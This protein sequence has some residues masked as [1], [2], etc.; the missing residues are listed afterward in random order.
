MD[1]PYDVLMQ[2]LELPCGVTVKNRFFKAP[3]S[4][5]MGAKDLGPTPELSKLY[6]RWAL[7][8]TGVLVTGNVMVDP[9]HMGEPGNVVVED[10]RHLSDLKQWATAGTANGAHLWMQLNHPGL[11]SP[12]SVNSSPVAPSAVKPP[13]GLEGAFAAPRALTLDEIDEIKQRFVTSATIAKKAGF[14]GVEVHAAHGY[15][16]SQF[17]SPATN[18]RTDAYGGSL[19]N[20]MRLLVE[21]VQSVREAVGT[22]FPIGVKL[23]SSD[24]DQSGFSEEDSLQVAARLSQLGV[25]VLDISGGTYSQPMMQTGSGV[26][27]ADYARRLAEVVH[28]PVALTGGFR[29]PEQ[30][31]EALTSGMSDLVGIGR[32]LVVNPELPNE[33]EAGH[34]RPVTLPRVTTGCSQLDRK[35]QGVMVNTW[36]ELQLRRIAQGRDVAM[37]GD[38]D[39]LRGNGWAAMLFALRMHGPAALKQRRLGKRTS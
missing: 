13:E 33:I 15:L 17:L 30:M 4:E 26:F 29:T 36:Y 27:F 32:P 28:T 19:D 9:R 1:Q 22:S 12:R 6:H 24:G 8:G 7:G 14:S 25:D 2:P 39:H 18:R 20:R 21:I 11:Q 37:H 35:L 23:N 31:A 3:M 16:L 38:G 5:A 10:E 34:V